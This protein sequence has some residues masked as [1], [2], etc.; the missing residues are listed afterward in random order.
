M[1]EKNRASFAYLRKLEGRGI[2]LGL[3]RMGKAIKLIKL[4]K[5]L[6]VKVAGTNGKGSCACLLAR[7]FENAGY[8]T[9]LYLSPHI[10]DFGERI[11]ID[12][13]YISEA[14]LCTRILELKEILEKNSVELSYFEFLT[15]LA[16]KYFS[17]KKCEAIVLEVGLGGRLDA[18]NVL[19]AKYSAITSVS[20]EHKQIL[21]STTRK[22]ARE[23]AGIIDKNTK[24][25][26]AVEN[27]SAL[28]EIKKICM[29]KN[30][31]LFN[32][33]K[34]F[35]CNKQQMQMHKMNFDFK[36][37]AKK[38]DFEDLENLKIAL[39]GK[40]QF[41][42]AAIAIAIA[43][44]IGLSEK[45][46]RTGLKEAEMAG[47]FDIRRKNPLLIFDNAHNP[48]AIKNLA[49][50][51]KQLFGNKKIILVFGVSSDKEY[52]KMLKE[53][54]QIPKKVYIT[55]AK[56]RGLDMKIL[57]KEIK[58]ILGK[59]KI[60]KTGKKDGIGL[61]LERNVKLAVK[62]AQ[63]EAEKDDIVLVC[64]SCFVVGEAL[65]KKNVRHSN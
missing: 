43:Q 12:G 42:S 6:V 8:K 33:G 40:R 61:I 30:A 2:R 4:K 49:D 22:I 47:R 44:Q 52:Q 36:A 5:M 17:D 7:I 63:K 21:G 35:F 59:N 3:E 32:Y 13:E 51:I 46:I 64:G 20:V 57:G 23:K 48:E 54:L 24:I 19:Q 25:F 55:Q 56:Y 26:T 38:A 50:T 28:A 62:R 10:V 34:D 9:G 37:N 15:L 14:E 53:I 16:L 29:E 45:A 58:K 31:E 39:V 65:A 41:A 11:Q 18:T 60:K 27:K 1:K